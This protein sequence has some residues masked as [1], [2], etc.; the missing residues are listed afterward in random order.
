VAD[1]IEGRNPVLE[2]LKAG[3]PLTKIL[4]SNTIERHGAVAEILHLAKTKG[5]P[6]EYVPRQ[7][8]DRRSLTSAHQGVMASAA[9]KEYFDLTDLF[10]ISEERGEPPFYVI[11][12]GIEDPQ[13]LGSIIRTADASA[14]H[15]VIIRSRRAV[16]LTSAVERASAGAVEHVPIARVVNIAQAVN[17]LKE[18]NIWVI[19]LDR[20]SKTDFTEVD[21]RPPTAIVIGSEG[22]GISDLVKKRCDILAS[23]PMGGKVT[24][25][26]AGVA[27]ALVMYEAFRQRR[28]A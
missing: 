3:R 6:V 11:L 15:G 22:S 14:V 17:F 9:V 19:G 1:N 12:D 18:H 10:S 27:A 23:I 16:G 25:L 7:V 26:N 2:A 24:S 28:R 20:E 4:L 21:Y 5:I 13:N 8:L